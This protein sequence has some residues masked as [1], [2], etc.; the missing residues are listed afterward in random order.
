MEL[1]SIIIASYNSSDFIL[2]TLQSI[3]DQTYKNIEL[4]V[5]DDCSKDDTVKLC[6]AWISKNSNRFSSVKL[7]EAKENGGIPTNCNSGIKNANGDWIKLFAADDVLE[8]ECIVS[9]LEEYHK[10]P[11]ILVLHCNVDKYLDTFEPSSFIGKGVDGPL[12]LND[13]S[14]DAKC[15]FEIL[16]RVNRVWA[17]TL[18]IHRS[19][20]DKVGLFDETNRLWEDTPMLIKITQNGIKLN[21]VDMVGAK[22]RVHSGSVKVIKSGK[23]LV[24]DLS[25]EMANYYLLHYLQ[26]MPFWERVVRKYS[27]HKMLY[28]EKFGWNV[29]SKIVKLLF[30]LS[31]FP[32]TIFL[33][34]YN[35]KYV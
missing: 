16:L 28:L 6:K 23:R 11:S 10:D 21:Y 8:P 20:Y 24:T 2:E 3:K 19:V 27:I 18:L 9:M 32:F 34:M 13:P 15:Q 1:V 12:K 35:K 33:K 29:N 17:P 26:H 30:T 22:Y 7:I 31:G 14:C 4:I 25:L 5:A